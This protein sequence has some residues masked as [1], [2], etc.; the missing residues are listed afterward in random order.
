MY[1]PRLIE[2]NLQSALENFPA[3]FVGG[4]RRAGKTMLVQHVLKEGYNYVLMDE[5]DIRAFAL[6]DP[7][8]FLEK[9]PPPVIIDEIQNA[10]QLLTYIKAAIE[11]EKKPGQWVLTGSQQW[12][13]MKGIGETLA[14]RIAI[15]HIYPFSLSEILKDQE[16]QPQGIGEYFQ[17]FKSLKSM[18]TP[19]LSAGEW[20]L[21][22]GYPEV[23]LGK[24]EVRRLWF[25]SYMQTYIDRDVRGNIREINLRDFERFVRLLAARTSQPLNASALAGEVGVTMPTIKTW[26][27][28]LEA[29]GLIIFLMPYYKNLGKR[30]IKASK[31]YFMDTGLVCYLVGLQDE[32]HTLQGPMAGALFETACVSQLFKRLSLWGNEGAMYYFRS[33]DGLEVDALIERADCCYPI[34]IKLSST[35]DLQRAAGLHKWMRLNK[36]KPTSAFVISSSREVGAMGEGISNIHF[37]LL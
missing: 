11:K 35:I 19:R 23:V 21:Q 32:A 36:D 15:L 3:V 31:C 8:G 26:L 22:G 30:L 20:I 1:L 4:P 7:R 33:S 17:Y 37:S 14:G 10:P 5:M 2:Q 6:E 18:P 16:K 28:L 25:S 27:T 12:A 29:S 34:E 13:L 9:Y 24:K